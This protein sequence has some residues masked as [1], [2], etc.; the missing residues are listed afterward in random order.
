[1][2]LV[3]LAVGTVLAEYYILAAQTAVQELLAPPAPCGRT[4]SVPSAHNHVPSKHLYP[5]LPGGDHNFSRRVCAY[6]L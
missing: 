2:V 4:D 5:T 3:V 6:S 1:M